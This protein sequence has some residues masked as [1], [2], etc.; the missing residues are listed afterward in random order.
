MAPSLGPAASAGRDAQAAA[1]SPGPAIVSGASPGPA[2]A[3][4]LAAVV[5]AGGRGERLGGA[6]KPLL[7]REGRPLLQHAVD[8]ALAANARP[9][10]V[11]GPEHTLARST[12]PVRWTREDPP[13]AGPATAVAAGLAALAAAPD[14]QAWVLLL[15]ADLANA[16][17]ALRLLLAATAGRSG[18]GNDDA[19]DGWVAVDPDGRRQPLCGVYRRAALDEAVDSLRRNGSAPAARSA[20]QPEARPTT[21]VGALAGES[22]RALLRPLRLAE[23]ELPADAVADVDTV[24]DARRWNVPL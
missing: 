14:Q 13:F 10:V 5:L 17:D 1:G 23:V 22:L 19:R 11:V 8:A 7:R 16:A 20:A 21:P 4:A 6:S 12:A 2:S 24:A 15:A 18:G 3:G 9:V